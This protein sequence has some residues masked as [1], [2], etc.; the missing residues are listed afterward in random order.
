MPL[1]R[2]A[3]GLMAVEALISLITVAIVLARSVSL[4]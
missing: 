1:S 4:I 2:W 3:K